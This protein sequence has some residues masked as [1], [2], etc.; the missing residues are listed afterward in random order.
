MFRY[1]PKDQVIASPVDSNSIMM[2]PIPKA[3]TLDGFSAGL[4]AELSATD[5]SLVADAYN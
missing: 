1:Y 4:T 5:K 2:Y 3:W